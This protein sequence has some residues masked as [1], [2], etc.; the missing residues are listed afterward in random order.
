MDVLFQ[1]LV[2]NSTDAVVMVNADGT[3]RRQLPSDGDETDSSYPA[4]LPQMISLSPAP[5][6]TAT[7][8]TFREPTQYHVA[9]VYQQVPVF[10]TPEEEPPPDGAPPPPPPPPA[11]TPPPPP[12]VPPPPPAPEE[13]CQPCMNRGDC[14][15]ME[16]CVDGCC[17][18]R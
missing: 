2:E 12:P 17:V 15:M 4:C 9:P 5:A 3:N 6:A 7:V 13:T 1:A 16:R 11:T 10:T 18:P 8:P 14:A